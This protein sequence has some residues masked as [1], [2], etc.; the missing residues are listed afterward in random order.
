MTGCQ[1]LIVFRVHLYD[2]TFDEGL[3]NLK[4]IERKFSNEQ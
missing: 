2:I 1:S 3:K 4:A